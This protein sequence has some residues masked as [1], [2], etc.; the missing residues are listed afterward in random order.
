LV[1]PAKVAIL[2]LLGATK[3]GTKIGTRYVRYSKRA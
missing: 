1:K 2:S 3:I